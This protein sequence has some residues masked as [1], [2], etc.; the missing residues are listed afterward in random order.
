LEEWLLRSVA[1]LDLGAPT[2]LQA[3]VIPAALRP[4]M[5]GRE[6]IAAAA[7]TGR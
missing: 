1:S 6:V 7:S 5:G 4:F 2:Q 3:E